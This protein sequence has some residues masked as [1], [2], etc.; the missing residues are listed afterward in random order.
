MIKQLKAT[1]LTDEQTTTLIRWASSLGVS[2]HE[3]TMRIISAALDGDRYI[4][5]MPETTRSRAIEEAVRSFNRANE[6]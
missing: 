5:R 1:R 3:V 2:V 4:E 6:L